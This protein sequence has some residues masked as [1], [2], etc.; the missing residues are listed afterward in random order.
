[1]N[2]SILELFQANLKK[3]IRIPPKAI[4]IHFSKSA[5]WRRRFE[6]L[7]QRFESTFQR[8]QTNEGDSNPSWRDS[9]PNSSEQ[10]EDDRF[11][12]LIKRFES[13]VK[14]EEKQRATNSNPNL[15]IRIPY[16]D[17]E[18]KTKRRIRIPYTAIRIPISGVL[19]NKARRFESSR[20]RFESLDKNKSRRLKVRRERFESS[21]YGFESLLA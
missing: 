3:A 9:N 4:W 17:H 1:M 19:M 2:S 14:K 15:A 11:E 16:E 12:S 13:H 21:S 18:E 6:S 10:F 20:Y 5:D 8:V 7:P